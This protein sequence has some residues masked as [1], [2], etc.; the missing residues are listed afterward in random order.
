[1]DSMIFESPNMGIKLIEKKDA[2][3]NRRIPQRS[4]SQNDLCTNY[5]EK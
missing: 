5:V 4:Q 1:M 3:V 2:R